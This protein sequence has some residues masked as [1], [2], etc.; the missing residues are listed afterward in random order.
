MD[1]MSKR[2]LVRNASGEQSSLAVR[3]GAGLGKKKM[4]NETSRSADVFPVT[5]RGQEKVATYKELE[6]IRSSQKQLQK[7]GGEIKGV[8]ISWVFG[9]P[10]PK[11][12]LSPG[13]QHG[14]SRSANGEKGTP[15]CRY[16]KSY[17]KKVPSKEWQKVTPQNGKEPREPD[18]SSFPPLGHG[19]GATE[20]LKGRG[21]GKNEGEVTFHGAGPRDSLKNEK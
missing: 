8:Q 1:D 11:G 12:G 17:A 4:K 3:A 5:P 20:S 2:G 16:G 18:R 6:I 10:Q 21:M 14:N 19:V 13:G 9:V 7:S 15:L